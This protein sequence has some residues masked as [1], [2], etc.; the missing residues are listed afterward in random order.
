MRP[1]TAMA[2][3]RRLRKGLVLLILV[4][5]VLIEVSLLEEF[6]PY[7]WRH[8][9]DQ[10]TERIIPTGTYAPHPEMDWEFELDFRQHPWHRAV[11]Y[12][13]LG[14]LVLIDSFLI[15]ITWRGFTRLKSTA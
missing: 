13:V 6:L 12:G 8:A 9:I 7:K 3:S 10:Q 4:V 14:M 1:F 5:L 15:A 11:E 2:L